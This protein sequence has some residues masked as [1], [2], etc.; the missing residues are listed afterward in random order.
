MDLEVHFVGPGST[1][2]DFAGEIEL[3]GNGGVVLPDERRR[4]AGR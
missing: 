4:R 1:G 3:I 2:G